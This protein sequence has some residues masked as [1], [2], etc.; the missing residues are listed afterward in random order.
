M[1]SIQVPNPAFYKWPA[2]ATGEYI[3]ARRALL[4][5]EYALRNQIEEVASQRRA[6]PLGPILPTYT[7]EEGPKD[8]A[9][10]SPITKVT[11]SDV[12]KPG[13]L[14]HKT[15]VVYHLMMGEN[16]TKA[17]PGC[18]M[19]VDGLNGVAKH[20]AQRFNLVVIAKAPLPV[21][22]EYAMKRGW[23]D[24]RFLSSFGNSFNKDMGVEAPEWM[25]DMPQGPG[26]SV[27]KYEEDDGEGKVRFLYQTNPHFDRDVIRGMDLLTPVWNILDIT[28]EGRG[29]WDPGFEYV[30]K[31]DGVKF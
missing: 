8:L 19:F 20:L 29:D 6:L 2:S 14:S 4:E 10:S 15:L 26:M 21:I 24:L 31:W 17:C 13:S 25:D 11:L 22:R 23:H 30:E 7:F 18:S 3:A 5:K 27:F 9:A 12:A 28:P 16:A 1:T